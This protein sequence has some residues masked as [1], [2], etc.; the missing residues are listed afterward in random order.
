MAKRTYPS[1]QAE[2]AFAITPSDTLLIPND[3]NNS[4]N[5]YPWC[6]V[7]NNSAGATVKVQTVQG[8][9]VTVWV[10]QGEVIGG[11]LPLMV[12][13]VFNTIPSPP[14]SLTALIPFG[15]SF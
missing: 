12:K 15:G 8:T 6:Y 5:Q 10:N 14:V 9:T 1:L 4:T 7:L 13:Q 11:D 3:P 2:D